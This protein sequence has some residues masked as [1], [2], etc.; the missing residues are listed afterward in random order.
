K[1]IV[2]DS[3]D[4]I[5]DDS[6]DMIV[7]ES[8]MVEDKSLKKLVDETMKLDEEHC[9]SYEDATKERHTLSYVDNSSKSNDAMERKYTHSNLVYDSDCDDVPNSQPSFM[10][11]ISSSGSDVLPEVPNLDNMDNNMINQGVQTMPSSE[12]SSIVNHLETEITSNSNI[13]PY[14]QYLHETQ[15]A[16][17]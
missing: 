6:L 1:M 9:Q 3:L 13:I 14:S 11:N 12:Q 5:K 2:D 7:D 16:A 4:M 10:A 15:Q 8:L 17:I